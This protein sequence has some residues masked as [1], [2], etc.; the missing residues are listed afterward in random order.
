PWRST[1]PSGFALLGSCAVELNRGNVGLGHV[2]LRKAFARVDIVH[3]GA[4][5]GE[6]E[7][8]AF[9][10]AEAARDGG[11]VE[12]DAI[13]YRAALQYPQELAG[14]VTADPDAALGVDAQAV[15]LPR[16]KVSIKA[17]AR[18]TAVLASVEGGQATGPGL[19]DDERP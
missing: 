6:E 5:R 18:Q 12:G 11:A 9:I 17:S 10:S 2:H 14:I 8:R 13:G 3:R 15:G 4:A 16:A 1:D 7:R 19:G